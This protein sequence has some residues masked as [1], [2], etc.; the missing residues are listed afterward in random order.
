M[1]AVECAAEQ[2][3]SQRRGSA[4][5]REQTINGAWGLGTGNN[6]VVDEGKRSLPSGSQPQ[7]AGS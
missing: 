7:V 4:C 5:T 1:N 6:D 2:R 3:D